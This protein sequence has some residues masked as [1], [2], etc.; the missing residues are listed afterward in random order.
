MFRQLWKLCCSAKATIVLTSITT[1]IAVLGSTQA[2]HN[3]RLFNTMDSKPLL[4]WW[5]LYIQQISYS[6]VWIPLCSALIGLLWF[7]TL[8]CCIDWLCHLRTRWKKSG[9]YLI[10]LGFILVV[11]AYAWGSI[12]GMRSSNNSIA[13]GEI[14]AIPEQAGYFLRLN[15]FQPQMAPSGRPIDMLSNVTLLKGD[16]ELKTATIRFNHPLTYGD[17]IILPGSYSQQVVG[18]SC[19]LNQQQVELKPGST[20]QLS[21]GA[22]LRVV[23]FTPDIQSRRG[24]AGNGALRNPAFLLELKE[25]SHENKS[26]WYVVRR[27]APKQ[28]VA[29]GFT[30]QRLAPLYTTYSQLTINRDPGAPLAAAGA[31]AMTLGI[32]LSLRSFYAKRSRTSGN[33]KL[34]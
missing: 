25:A 5:Q 33:N 18:F 14:I 13:A 16:H 20:I 6:T 10:H 22:S 8:C 23:D 11:I 9:E 32:L 31:I 28:L 2:M 29:A 30:P 24:S 27:G 15:S 34:S 1:L 4:E 26:L 21:A 17:L 7:N 19:L 12:Y 3:P